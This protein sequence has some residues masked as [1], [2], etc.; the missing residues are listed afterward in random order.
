MG[1]QIKIKPEVKGGKPSGGST[2]LNELGAELPDT[3]DIQLRIKKAIA[4]KVTTQKRR[5]TAEEEFARLCG[6]G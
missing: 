3:S 5:E 6:C 1:E 4:E 2:S